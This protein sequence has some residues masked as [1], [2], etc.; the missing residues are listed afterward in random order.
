MIAKGYFGPLGLVRL[1]SARR[2]SNQTARL[3]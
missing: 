2:R 3:N 1:R